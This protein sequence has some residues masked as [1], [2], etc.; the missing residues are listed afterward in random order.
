METSSESLISLRQKEMA[1]LFVGTLQM[2]IIYVLRREGRIYPM[3]YPYT[4]KGSCTPIRFL[5]YFY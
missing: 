3:F 1:K 2:I 5:Q 4:G